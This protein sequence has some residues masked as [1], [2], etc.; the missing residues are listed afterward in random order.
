MSSVINDH[1]SKAKNGW[2]TL[3][4]GLE[5]REN[6]SVVPEDGQ[7]AAWRPEGI[8]GGALDDGRP[9]ELGKGQDL[10]ALRVDGGQ[11][12]VPR[13]AVHLHPASRAFSLF[14][15]FSSAVSAY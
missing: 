14:L 9:G 3:P 6:L 1:Q 5:V 10:E 13:P 7:I 11:A 15:L 2:C 12:P 8:A 4:D